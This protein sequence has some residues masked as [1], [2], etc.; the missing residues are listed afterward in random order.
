MVY[1]FPQPEFKGTPG[2]KAFTSDFLDRL[3]GFLEYYST[4]LDTEPRK[5]S[6]ITTCFP[7]GSTAAVWY[8]SKK[9]TFQ[10]VNQFITAFT[11]RFSYG[12]ADASSLLERLNRLRQR[13]SESVSSFYTQFQKTVDQLAALNVT[14]GASDIATRFTTALRPALSAEVVRARNT[15]QSALSLDTC[16]RIAEANEKAFAPRVDRPVR[17]SMHGMEASKP[18]CAYHKTNAHSTESCTKVKA[19]KAAGKWRASR[20]NN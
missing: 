12:P 19:L 6:A 5:L 11:E 7:S 2:E 13:D 3:A 4:D 9:S 16:V 1:K 18:Y 20:K 8:A 10:T 14:F 17:P 15:S